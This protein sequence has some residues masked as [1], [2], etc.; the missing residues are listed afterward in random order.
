MVDSTNFVS[1]SL[2]VFLFDGE[3]VIIVK[4]LKLFFHCNLSLFVFQT[5]ILKNIKLG[6][7]K[8]PKKSFENL[9]LVL[10]VRL[11]LRIEIFCLK[12]EISIKNETSIHENSIIQSTLQR[13]K[14]LKPF[15]NVIFLVLFYFVFEN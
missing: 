14:K 2:I 7:W 12:G 9:L 13:T 4:S 1:S 11:R 10:E 6:F 15:D 8:L 5:I 3:N